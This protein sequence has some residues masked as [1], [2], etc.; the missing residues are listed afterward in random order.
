MGTQKL[1]SEKKIPSTVK[2]SLGETAGGTTEPRPTH[3]AWMVLETS[4]L[5]LR[6]MGSFTIASVATGEQ[7]V[8]KTVRNSVTATL[9]RTPGGVP[10]AGTGLGLGSICLTAGGDHGPTF[11]YSHGSALLGRQDDS[12]TRRLQEALLAVPEA[13]EYLRLSMAR[14]ESYF[15]SLEKLL[16]LDGM[17]MF[18]DLGGRHYVFDFKN[19]RVMGDDL[20]CYAGSAWCPLRLDAETGSM[21]CLRD[22]GGWEA[23]ASSRSKGLAKGLYNVNSS[24]LDARWRGFDF[25]PASE[26]SRILMSH[27]WRI[28]PKGAMSL[29]T[30]P[31]LAVETAGGDAL[32]AAKAVSVNVP[33]GSSLKTEA[34]VVDRSATRVPRW[35]V[36]VQ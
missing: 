36:L 15:S 21:E 32:D 9:L 16:D 30:R 26:F 2:T 5:S 3:G 19:M 22:N 20:G 7:I 24:R 17:I 4:N 18:S 1:K 8:L 33:S 27:L 31:P 29:V 6:T 34:S 11:S 12:L 13:S 35:L 28:N 14:Q 25:E 10:E 23:V